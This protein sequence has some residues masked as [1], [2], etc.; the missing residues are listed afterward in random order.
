MTR[1]V[2]LV[3][4]AAA[5]TPATAHA[6]ASEATYDVTFKAQMTETWKYNENYKDDCELTGVLCTRDEVGAGSANLQVKSRR[7][8]RMLVIRGPKGRPPQIGVGTGEGIPLT[9][10]V[11]RSGSLTT[12]YGGPWAP[13]NPNRKAEDKGCGNRAIKSDVNFSWQGSNQLAPLTSS[14]DLGDTDCPDGPNEP[15]E[16][17]GGESPSLMKALTTASPNKFLGTKQFTVRGQRTWTGVIPAFNNGALTRGGDTKVTWTWEATFR[18][19]KK[20]R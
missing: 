5:L 20:R 1:A 16:W 14:L 11:L 15:W 9:G 7:P 10:S 13:A 4:L 12:T 18:K 8:T 19:A 3:A 2:L 6:A 17:A